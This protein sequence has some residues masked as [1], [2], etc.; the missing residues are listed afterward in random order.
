VLK[1]Y[2]V[3]FVGVISAVDENSAR[4]LGEEFLKKYDLHQISVHKVREMNFE[5]VSP[6]LEF[7]REEVS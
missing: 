7:N 5:T 2:I 3:Y 1:Q 6:C 4:G